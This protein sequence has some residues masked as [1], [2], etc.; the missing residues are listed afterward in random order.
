MTATEN[1]A[2]ANAR[3]ESDG[4]SRRRPGNLNAREGI[5]TCTPLAAIRRIQAVTNVDAV[6]VDE[7]FE[8]DVASVELGTRRT[9]SQSISRS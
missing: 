4:D 8:V 7:D 9:C 3:A 5:C 6:V 1:S 2:R